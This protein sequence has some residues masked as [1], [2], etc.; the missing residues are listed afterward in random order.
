M[1]GERGDALAA[2]R[3]VREAFHDY[4]SRFLGITARARERFERRDWPGALADAAERLGVHDREV[5]HAIAALDERVGAE[6]RSEALWQAARTAYALAI[7]AEPGRELAETFFNSVSRRVLGTV[8]KNVRVEFDGAPIAVSPLGEDPPVYARSEWEG[9][10]AAAVRR[11]LDGCGLRAPFA[12][13][14]RDAQRIAGRVDAH[15]RRILDSPRI[16]AIE[17]LRPVLFRQKLAY[18]VGRIR[19]QH[20]LLPLVLVL[21]HGE[22]G[23]EVDAVLLSQDEISIVFSFTRSHFHAM[24]DR[25][26]DL[27]PFLKSIM[28][29]KPLAELYIALG[30]HKHGKTELYRGLRDHL[31]RTVDRFSVAAG[32]PGMVMLVFTLP[33]Y[34][35]VFK[36]I[37]D[38]FAPPKATTRRDVMERYRLV[39]TRDRVGRLVE[40]QEFEHL[41][42]P[43]ERF[44]PDLLEQLLREAA[45]TVRV[46]GDR[47]ILAH[48]YIE[49]KVT[50]LNLYLQESVRAH[51]EEAVLDYGRAIKELAMANVFPGDFLLKNFGVTRHGRV[52]FYDYDELC[53]L[54]DCRFRRLPQPRTP[55]D[56]L[57]AEPW[58]AAG[59]DDVFP[60]EFASFLRLPPGLRAA[61]ERHH[62]DI[63]DPAFWNDV[64][65]RLVRGEV[66]DVFPYAE[67]LRLG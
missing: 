7:A 34:G 43:L 26:R 56:E 51:A 50:P 4:L 20:H 32:D 36:V 57:A 23:I 18:V 42:F 62:A 8:G 5:E 3:I 60:E 17:T 13:A 21:R 64:Q 58:F 27:L 46:H 14:E 6:A 29:L 33:F 35:I 45:S 55:E 59:P 65:Q 15:L 28:P 19:R 41:D 47:V 9:D 1:S 48:V 49:R 38:R 10:T 24:C 31:E 40:A 12:D 52:V 53:L 2:A 25:P 22:R 54:T 37:R 44:E 30:F 39:F 16:D 11:I 66:L 61:F 63:L 67:S